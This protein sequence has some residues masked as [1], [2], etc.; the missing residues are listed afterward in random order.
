MLLHP[1]LL[2]LTL[3]TPGGDNHGISM[4]PDELSTHLAESDIEK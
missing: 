4:L 3:I 2:I 1:P